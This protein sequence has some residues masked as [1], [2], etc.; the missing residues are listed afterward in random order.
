[1]GGSLRLI[2]V[3]DLDL[4]LYPEGL[5]ATEASPL[6]VPLS[7]FSS[8]ELLHQLI[9]LEVLKRLE[10]DP[11]AN[12]KHCGLLVGGFILEQS[13]TPI[14]VPACCGDLSN[15]HNWGHA[16]AGRE[17][18]WQE[19]WIGHPSAVHRLR[20]GR[21]ELAL[22]EEGG[23]VPDTAHFSMD[24]LELSKAIETARQEVAAFRDRL[25]PVLQKLGFKSPKAVASSILGEK[26]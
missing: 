19:L 16:A 11:S 23:D 10:I 7:E 25:V 5:K 8:P 17:K 12:P 22:V 20:D 4:T 13:G 15:L 14:I 24:P 6:H 3:L 1:M 26:Q 21:L 9:E 2:P 18:V